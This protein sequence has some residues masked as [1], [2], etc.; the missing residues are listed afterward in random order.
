L[1]S[2]GACYLSLVFSHSV[3]PEYRSTQ[4][5]SDLTAMKT[6]PRPATCKR[7]RMFKNT[8]VLLVNSKRTKKKIIN[9]MT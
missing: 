6:A 1:C 2:R 8:R 7:T 5:G 9:T 4:A 3:L